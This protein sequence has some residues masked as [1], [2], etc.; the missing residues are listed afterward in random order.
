MAIIRPENM[1]FSKQTF[2]AIIYGSPGTGKT[3]LA[4]S[5][6]SPVLIDFDGG[7]SRVRAEHRKTTIFCKTYEEVKKDVE[8]PEMAEFQTIVIDTGG[9]FITFLK[10]WAISKGTFMSNVTEKTRITGGSGGVASLQISFAGSVLPLLSFRTKFS[11]DGHVQTQVKRNGGG[12]TLEH[13]FV[14]SIFGNAAVF[15]RVGSPRFPV[16][17]KFGPSTGHMMQNEK[18]IEKME[19][20]ISETYERRIEHEILRVLNGWGG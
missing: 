20:T 10:D 5:A 19:Q 11:R 3:T 15:E 8:S 18:V 13:A 9:S 4:L 17:Q 1:D 16:E 6:P 2:S 12:A 14:A 7:V